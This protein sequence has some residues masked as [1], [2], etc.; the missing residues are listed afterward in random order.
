[1]LNE[2][3]VNCNARYPEEIVNFDPLLI[4]STFQKK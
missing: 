1:M 3:P 4:L 2:R